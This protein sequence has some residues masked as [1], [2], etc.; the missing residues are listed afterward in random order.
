MT[1][2]GL[3]NFE[4]KK[5]MV[6]GLGLSGMAMVRFLFKQKA[7]VSV[8]DQRGLPAIK[9]QLSQAGFSKR[10]SSMTL[11]SGAQDDAKGSAFLD[12][13]YV[14]ISPGIPLSLPSLVA[15]RRKKIPILG[16]FGVAASRL[17]A[18]MIGVTGTNGKSTTVTLIQELL[19]AGGHRSVL[20][21]NIGVPLLDVVEKKADWFVAEISSYQLDTV[22]RLRPRMGVLLNVTDDHLDRYA[23]FSAYG[24]SKL[25]LIEECRGKDLI[26]YNRDDAFLHRHLQ[27]NDRARKVSF[28]LKPSSA[29]LVGNLWGTQEE[30]IYRKSRKQIESYSL[31]KTRLVG[32]HHVQNM[33]ASIAVAREAGIPQ[34]KIQK[35]LDRFKGLPHRMEFVRELDGVRYYEDS[36]ATNVDAVVK[37]LEGFG[38]KQVVLLAGGRDKGGS[39]GPLARMAAQKVKKAVLFGESKQLIAKDLKRTTPVALCQN[40]SEAVNRASQIAAPGDVV[41]LSPACSS[42][43]Q[44]KDYKERGELFQRLVKELDVL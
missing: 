44:F 28:S 5:V 8:C 6:V 16:E 38:A 4:G 25:R 39:Y 27:K 21:G 20:A 30:I 11:Y 35:V 9:A 40:L 14:M 37:A 1:R 32:L 42:F 2:I 33:M 23:S 12:Q 19:K 13:D 10:L 31:Q 18:P 24:R 3:E 34:M 26:V 22:T 15:V 43:D 36:K 7:R 17:S 41:L 29:M